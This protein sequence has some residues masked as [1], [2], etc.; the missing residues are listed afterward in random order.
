MEFTRS[1]VEQFAVRN[2]CTDVLAFLYY[3][4]SRCVCG[5]C[6]KP[7]S[8]CFSAQYPVWPLTDKRWQLDEPTNL[9]RISMSSLSVTALKDVMSCLL[10]GTAKDQSLCRA[11]V[12]RNPPSSK[13]PLNS[14]PVVV[15][16]TIAPRKLVHRNAFCRPNSCTSG[17][18]F[19]TDGPKSV[20]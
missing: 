13:P 14:K 10:A 2:V 18:H 3:S 1:R 17:E 16:R 7:C 9:V 11:L 8:C 4:L 6:A 15:P 19:S 5:C 20:T 12:R